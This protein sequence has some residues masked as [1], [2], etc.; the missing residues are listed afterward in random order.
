MITFIVTYYAASVGGM[1]IANFFGSL[2]YLLFGW[3]GLLPDLWI[4]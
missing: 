3:T 2:V 1:T 4:S